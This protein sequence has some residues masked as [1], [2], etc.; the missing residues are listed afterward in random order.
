[1][2]VQRT[3]WNAINMK[4]KKKVYH[5]RIISVKGQW[6][7][8]YWNSIKGKGDNAMNHRSGGRLGFQKNVKWVCL[9][10]YRLPEVQ[11][12]VR[13]VGE[14]MRRSN[15]RK[16]WRR[17][18]EHPKDDDL[19]SER[20]GKPSIVSSLPPE[21]RPWSVNSLKDGAVCCVFIMQW[22]SNMCAIIDIYYMCVYICVHLNF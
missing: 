5:I 17:P 4:N 12:I 2:F 7:P 13:Y 1:M 6:T 9:T 15:Q 14:D 10:Q 18:P 8:L 16:Q 22:K 11:I 19:A 3:W 21:V 20:W